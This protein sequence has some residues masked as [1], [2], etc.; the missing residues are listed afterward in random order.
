MRVGTFVEN[1]DTFTDAS[2]TGFG[3]VILTPTETIIRAQKWSENEDHL[4]INIKE[5]KALLHGVQLTSIEARRR[6]VMPH[7]RF[8]V[9]NTSVIGSVEKTHSR[10]Y[11]LNKEVQQICDHISRDAAR[12]ST[13]TEIHYIRSAENIADGPSR[14]TQCSMMHITMG[15]YRKSLWEKASKKDTELP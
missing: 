15:I 3:V 5:A 10:S 12:W 8:H 13:A 14:Q 4:H 7:V 11:A 2:G 9:D 6:H 1:W